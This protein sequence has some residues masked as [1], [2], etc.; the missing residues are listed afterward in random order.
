MKP[1]LD[2]ESVRR[3][4]VEMAKI[5]RIIVAQY[6]RGEYVRIIPHDKTKA[7]E[8]KAML[9]SVGIRSSSSRRKGEVRVYE[10]RSLEIIKTA[11]FSIKVEAPAG[12]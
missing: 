8:I 12:I 4:L 5:A 11:L 10:K 9:S 3:M 2:V 6:K 1:P 7:Y